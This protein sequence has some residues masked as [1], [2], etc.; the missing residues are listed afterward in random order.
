M[1]DSPSPDGVAGDSGLAAR[2]AQ[3]DPRALRQVVEA[4]QGPLLDLGLRLL[5]DRG[6]AE[7]LV[8]EVFLQAL[9]KAGTYQGKGTLRGWLFR[10]ATHLALNRLRRPPPSPAG[11]APASVEAPGG[12]DD[13]PERTER[14]RAVRDAVASLPERQR[15]A[16]VLQR[17]EGLSYREIAAALDCT[18]GAVESL[19]HRAHETL[20]R[21]LKKIGN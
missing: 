14:A 11:A 13:A 3:G 19:L 12:P 7:D 6:E 15:V 5:R 18:V 2:L 17:F 21:R 16:V 20:R 8:Q 10:I 1:P 4:F 9:R